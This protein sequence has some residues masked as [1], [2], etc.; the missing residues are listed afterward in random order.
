MVVVRSLQNLALFII[1]STLIFVPIMSVSAN[2][3][4]SHEMVANNLFYVRAYFPPL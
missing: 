1:V 3:A 2:E 4:H